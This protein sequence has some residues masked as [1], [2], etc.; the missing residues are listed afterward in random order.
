M[1]SQD[2]FLKCAIS[3]IDIFF[4]DLISC[5]QLISS[6]SLT[7][8]HLFL[9]RF[10]RFASQSFFSFSVPKYPDPNSRGTWVW[11][12]RVGGTRMA[13]AGFRVWVQNN[14]IWSEPVIWLHSFWPH[15]AT[16]LSMFF[17]VMASGV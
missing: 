10:F 6:V 9:L 4:A 3:I 12:E 8:F 17:F 15:Q 13:R 2:R 7:I 1:K 16:N 5:G 11:V 14:P